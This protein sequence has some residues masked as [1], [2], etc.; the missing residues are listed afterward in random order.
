MSLLFKPH[1]GPQTRFMAYTGRYALMGGAAMG[2]KSECLRWDPW[3]QIMVETKRVQSGEI[4]TS[5]GR[6]IF[7]RR[8]MPELREVMD[9][10]ARD[11]PLI[12]KGAKWHEQTKTWTMSCGYKY[13]FGQMEEA[14]DWVK[15]YGFEFTWVGFDELTTFEEEQYD[16]LDTRLRSTDPVLKEMLYM[17]A[18]T[19][20]VGR[21]LEWVRR[22]FVEVAPPGTPVKLKIKV[23]TLKDGVQRQETVEREQIFIPAKV[24]DN[25]S[26]DQAEYAATLTT[27]SRATREALLEGNWYASSESCFADFWDSAIHICK[28]FPIP[29]GWTK[30]RCCD[31]GTAWPSLA[32]VQWYAIDRDGNAIVYRSLT[33]TG[34]NAEMLAYRI[35]EIEIDND[36]WDL[37]RGCSMLRGPLDYSCWAQTGSIGPTIA[38]TMFHVGVLWDKCDKN[39]KFAADQFRIRLGKRS[40]HPTI[41]DDKGQP[42]RIVPGIRWF[43]TCW[44]YVRNPRGQKVKVGP[45]VTIPTLPAD[46]TDPD[47]PDTDA[48][49]HDY[50]AISYFCMSRP[51][52]ALDNNT[53]RNDIAD[54]K[55]RQREAAKPK[56]GKSGYKNM[57]V[58]LVPLLT[59]LI[60][61]VQ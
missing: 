32:S 55:R 30:G 25:P 50:D 6:S 10:C 31:F 18:T 46:E 56:I 34:H 40:P 39:R 53:P 49:D 19:N 21:G 12:D 54:W 35:K 60:G 28:P 22:R 57:W 59:A 33:V 42:A 61:A 51:L 47:V 37:M 23:T 5:T 52:S 4:P 14:G 24:S 48:N 41:K 16:Q 44:N 17:R 29:K 2:G 15:Y 27:K 11:F 36:E 26:A 45:I 43:D 3:R 13:M 8:T 9:R 38:E 1:P 58:W 20:P 7:F